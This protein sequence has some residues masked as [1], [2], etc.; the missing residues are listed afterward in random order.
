MVKKI[1]FLSFLLCALISLPF[2]LF[3]LEETQVSAEIEG[4]EGIENQP[5]KGTIT[6]THNQNDKVV[7][8]SYVLEK[9]PLKLELVKEVQIIPNNPLTLSIYSF[10]IPGKPAGLY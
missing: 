3:A 4:N 8:N 10:Q 1:P 9:K 7:L 6:I 5:L 2:L